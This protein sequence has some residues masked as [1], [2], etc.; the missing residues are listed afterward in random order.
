MHRNRTRQPAVINADLMLIRGLI[1][2]G[3]L[4]EKSV[5]IGNNKKK[6]RC[7]LE[8]VLCIQ[9]AVFIITTANGMHPVFSGKHPKFS[10]V[11]DL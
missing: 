8:N 4:R 6:L 11:S 7:T 9:L 3:K 5:N 2:F 10:I 1:D